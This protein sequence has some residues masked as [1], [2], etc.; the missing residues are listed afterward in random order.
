LDVIDLDVFV[1]EPKPTKFTDKEG[2][3]LKRKRSALEMELGSIKSSGSFLAR[4]FD[5]RKAIEAR[6]KSL[7]A[8]IKRHTHTVDISSASFGSSMYVLKH[9]DEF[10]R[11]ETID[12]DKV[13]D[14]EYRLVLGI[15][16]DACSK[17]G[18]KMTVDYLIDNLHVSQG[19]VMMQLVMRELLGY[20]QSNFLAAAGTEQGK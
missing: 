9:I 19:L 2:F 17:Q 13:T 16:A 12:P 3:E 15:V 6:I 10:K 5:K 14:R 4:I 11:L 1:P 7:D 18:H 8:E 20:I